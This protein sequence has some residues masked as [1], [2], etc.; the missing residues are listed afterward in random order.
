MEEQFDYMNMN[1]PS[2]KMMNGLNK[3]RGREKYTEKL[4]VPAYKQLWK[5]KWK[6]WKREIPHSVLTYAVCV[7]H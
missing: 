1:H 7:V 2:N 3:R 5:L 4:Q 6:Y